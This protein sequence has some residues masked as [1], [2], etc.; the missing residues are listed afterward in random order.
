M[1]HMSNK[2]L[3]ISPLG[4]AFFSIPIKRRPVLAAATP[5]V[6]LPIVKSRTVSP[7]LV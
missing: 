3:I 2:K 6:P 1:P 4:S 7:G 5:V